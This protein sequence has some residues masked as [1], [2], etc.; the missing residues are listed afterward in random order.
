LK[1]RIIIYNQDFIFQEILL[2]KVRKV[3]LYSLGYLFS[4]KAAKCLA[5]LSWRVEVNLW[6]CT[7]EDIAHSCQYSA[8]KNALKADC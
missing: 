6:R 1:D 2:K 7:G 5:L 4:A 3:G 8:I